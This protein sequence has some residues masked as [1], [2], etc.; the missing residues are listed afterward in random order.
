[1][2][3]VMQVGKG[4]AEGKAQLV[5]VERPPEQDWQQFH[6]GLRHLTGREDFAA[7]RLVMGGQ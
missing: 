4:F 2:H 1:M 6:C 7:A 5:S 3:Q